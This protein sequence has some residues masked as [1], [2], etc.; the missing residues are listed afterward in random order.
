MPLPN[1]ANSLKKTSPSSNSKDNKLEKEQYLYLTTRGRKSGVPREIEIWFTYRAG[2]FYVI[3]E[4]P[5]S[6]WVQNLVACPEVEVRIAENSFRARAQ[7]IPESDLS[8]ATQNFSR[9]K[10]GWGD[11]LVVELTPENQELK[12]EN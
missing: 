11:G 6:N 2:H 3:A 5:T 7:V 4:Y 1:L 10:Y 8:R 9:D 12:A